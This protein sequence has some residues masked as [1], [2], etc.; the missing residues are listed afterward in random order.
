MAGGDQSDDDKTETATSRHL[1]QARDGGQVP[2][3]REVVTF[4]SMAAVTLV[5]IYQSQAI[6][7]RLLPDML[8]Y[9]AHAGETHILGSS[10]SPWRALP[11]LRAVSPFLVT[12][13]IAGACAVLMQTKFLLHL[14]APQLELSRV[15][16]TA[17]MKRIF[18]FHGLV[19]VV[20]SLGKLGLLSMAIWVATRG[21][22]LTLTDMPWQDAERLLA[23]IARPVIHLFVAGL[24][25]QAIVA[26]ADIMWVRFRH[27]Q[28]LRMSKQDV[29]DEMKDTDGNPHIKARI[30]RIRVMR[31]RKRMMAKVPTATVV[32]T[33]PTHYAVALAYDRAAHPAPRIVAKG[34]DSL[35]LRIREV[36]EANGVPVVANPP[37]ARALY[38]MDIDTQIPAEHFK[39]VA[40]IIGYVWRLRRPAAESFV[41]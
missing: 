22:W 17:G 37:L 25:V 6:M 31:A 24:C 33:N 40:E 41:F 34:S 12:A 27:A 38:L 5:L 10:L 28:D 16:P 11:V 21:D 2:M 19:E 20:K 7:L 39:A 15:S 14:G 13:V 8:A 9:I 36:A 29:R 3:S 26:A 32:V 30:R 1:D 4:V 23:S 35:A 18:G